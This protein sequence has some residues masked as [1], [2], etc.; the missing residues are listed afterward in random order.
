MRK[1]TTTLA[2]R[3]VRRPSAALLSATVR[4]VGLA[5]LDPAAVATFRRTPG[6]I[7]EGWKP[8]APTFL[9]TSDEQTIAAVA[10][11][12][13]AVA[14]QGGDVG[15]SAYADWGVVAAPRHL[16]RAQLVTA[17]ERFAAEGVWGV[18]P[19]L[20]PHFALHAPA[21]TLSLALAAHGPNLGVGGGPG[22]ATEGALTAL[23]W[24]AEGRLPGVWLV[25]T[26]HDPEF[27][28]VP[29]GKPAHPY[30]CQALALALTPEGAGPRLRIGPVDGSEVAGPP[31][32]VELH[33]RLASA[34]DG[35][36]IYDPAGPAAIDEGLGLRLEWAF[37]RDGSARGAW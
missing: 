26:G 30:E 3:P 2:P 25:L 34:L 29:G 24:L 7:P 16:G 28:P 36:S 11:V 8:I 1:T 23:T 20:I 35:G 9:K 37:G 14:G 12:L 21:G 4:A 15:P 10:A 31:D 27:V 33:A 19:H 22:A 5:R 17:L 13:A 6:P 32:L 18:S